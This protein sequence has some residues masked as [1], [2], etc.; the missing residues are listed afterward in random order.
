MGSTSDPRTRGATRGMA[1]SASSRRVFWWRRLAVLL[2]LPAVW[3]TWSITGA[4]IAPGTDSL[5]ARIAQWARLHHVG[6]AVTLAEKVQYQITKPATG[7]SASAIPT[8][9]PTEAPTPSASASVS[10]SPKRPPTSTAPGNLTPI[11]SGALANEGVWQDLYSASGEVAARGTYIRP[12]NEHTSFLTGVVWM[13]PKLLHFTLHPGMKVPGETGWAE[14]VKVPDA[15]RGSI[16]A[17]FNSGFMIVDSG[18]GFWQKGK[19][20]GDLRQGAASMVFGDDGSLDVRAWEGGAPGAG[21]HSVRQNLVLM[22]DGGEVT[23]AVKNAQ[24]TAVWGATVGNAAYVWRSGVGVRNDG[25]VVFVGGDALSI[26]TLAE[27]LK[28]AGCVRAMELDI[29][30]AWVNYMTYTQ[31]NGQ[32]VG[33][34]FTSSDE[35]LP[36][37]YL[38]PSNRDFV[39][40]YPKQ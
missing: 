22:V 11:A 24:A 18:G 13:D 23:P 6:W 32:P 26:Q 35:P 38:V 12:D 19:Q 1:A 36:G 14:E 40:I 7:G 5:A 20:V 30:K 31:E 21:V 28:R 9:G 27:L 10:A 34:M 8:L 29:N 2:L 33:K 25:T 37:R 15:K 3:F 16:L 4:I 39:A 17:S